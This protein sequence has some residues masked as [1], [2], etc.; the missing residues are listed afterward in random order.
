MFLGL[1]DNPGESVSSEDGFDWVGKA[2]SVGA[3][4]K[5][6]VLLSESFLSECSSFVDITYLTSSDSVTAKISLG[7]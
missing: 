4:L 5:E 1:M 7:K 3:V 6:D 2:D